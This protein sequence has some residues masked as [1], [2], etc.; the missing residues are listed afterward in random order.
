MTK[1]TLTRKDYVASC[2]QLL[3]TSCILAGFAFS[4]L[5]ALPSIDQQLFAKIVHF[6]AGSFDLAFFNSYYFLFF[7][8]LCFLCT[9][10]TILVYKASG[11]LIPI[12]KLWRVHLISNLIFSLAIASLLISV[13]ILGIP[14]RY[15]LSIAIICG[16]GVA[17]CFLWENMVPWQKQK[18]LQQLQLEQEE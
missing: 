7:S 9:I 15:G 2:D 10:L 13:I 16:V 1:V 4:G 18:R 6:F 5:I 3:T 8:T 14:S 17:S 12:K 11:Y